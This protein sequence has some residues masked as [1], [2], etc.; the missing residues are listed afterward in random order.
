V[1]T[2]GELIAGPEGLEFEVLDADPRRLKR[3]RIHRREVEPP[4]DEAARAEASARA[5]AD[6]AETDRIDAAVIEAVAP[7]P[8]E[9]AP[10]IPEAPHPPAADGAGRPAA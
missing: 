8:D 6:R 10:D 3:V 9:P 5:E 4:A 2:R 7:P 1:P